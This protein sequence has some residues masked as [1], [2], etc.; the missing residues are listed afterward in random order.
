MKTIF[1]FLLLTITGTA[2]QS[3]VLTSTGFESVIT[4]VEGK[5]SAELMQKAKDWIQYYYTNP[6]ATN[7]SEINE[8]YIRI[9]GFC[10][11]CFQTKSL[12]I[13]NFMNYDYVIEISFKEGK[14]KFDY[15]V[16]DFY[17]NRLKA[18]YHYPYF[19]KKDGTVKSIH[20]FS[21]DSLSETATKTYQ[22]LNDF[23]TGKTM[24]KKNDW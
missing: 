15:I 23:I 9:N 7:K 13:V 22:S 8:E 17:A 4:V 2:Q 24:A 21:V 11:S 3:M 16:G 5:S 12:G 1:L 20:Q 10:E 18:S 6:S 19:F 14:Y